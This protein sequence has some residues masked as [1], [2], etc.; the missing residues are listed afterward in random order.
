MI[1]SFIIFYVAGILL[2]GKEKIT[3]QKIYYSFLDFS[4]KMLI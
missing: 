3:E 2:G 1:M 4:P